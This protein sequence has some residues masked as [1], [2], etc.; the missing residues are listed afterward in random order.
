MFTNIPAA[1][2]SDAR[3]VLGPIFETDGLAHEASIMIDAG[4][5]IDLIVR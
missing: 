2:V 1:E 5:R 4:I 3:Y